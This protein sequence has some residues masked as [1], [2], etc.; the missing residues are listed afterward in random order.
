MAVSSTIPAAYI[1]SADFTCW[2]IACGPNSLNAMVRNAVSDCISI[3][4]AMKGDK[5]GVIA[6]FSEDYEA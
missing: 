3:K 2:A 1:L 4:K 6:L 5:T